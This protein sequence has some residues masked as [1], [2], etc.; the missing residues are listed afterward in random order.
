MAIRTH[1]SISALSPRTR[2]SATTERGDARLYAEDR[3]EH[4][5]KGARDNTFTQLETTFHDL[6]AY[7]GSAEQAAELRRATT[8]SPTDG[9]AAYSYER[10]A[11]GYEGEEFI[12]T[13]RSP[14]ARTRYEGP[15]RTP[16]RDVTAFLRQGAPSNATRHRNVSDPAMTDQFLRARRHA[17]TRPCIARSDAEP[18]HPVNWNLLTATDLGRSCSR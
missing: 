2:S 4:F 5:R 11:S 1:Q 12:A 13:H 16:G 18:P 3:I 9:C 8:S 17:R 6:I 10:V 15:P 14:P 7:R